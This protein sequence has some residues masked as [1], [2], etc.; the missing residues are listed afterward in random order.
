M[1]LYVILFD[2]ATKNPGKAGHGRDGYYF[3]IGNDSEY[4]MLQ[5]A[6]AIGEA[7]VEAGV[8][9]ESEPTTFAQEELAKY[10]GSEVS[11]SRMSML[12]VRIPTFATGDGCILWRKLAWRGESLEV[13][14]LEPEEGRQGHACEREVRKQDAPSEAAAE[15]GPYSTLFV[16]TLGSVG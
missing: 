4:S 14:W 3:G 9:K 2:S 1:D 8:H 5:L 6:S 7:M 13:P 10:F 16:N 12:C 15:V 11:P